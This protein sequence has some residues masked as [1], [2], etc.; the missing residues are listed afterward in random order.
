MGIKASTRSKTRD[1]LALQVSFVSAPERHNM[2][3]SLQRENIA[4]RLKANPLSGLVIT[5][6]RL[7]A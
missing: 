1:I 6:K 5:M 7:D 3:D 4:A 2:I